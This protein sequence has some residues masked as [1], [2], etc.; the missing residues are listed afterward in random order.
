MNSDISFYSKNLYPD[1]KRLL[2]TLKTKTKKLNSSGIQP[3]HYVIALSIGLFCIY[4]CTE[5][6][7]SFWKFIFGTTAAFA[8][9]FL[10]FTPF[11]V[12][13]INKQRKKLI[14]NIDNII[15]S[16]S[17]KSSIVRAKRIAYAPEYEDENDLYLIELNENSVLHIWDTEYN[18][19]GKF[20]CLDFEIYDLDYFDI[21]GRQIYPLSEKIKPIKIDKKAKWNYMSKYNVIENLGKESINFDILLERYRKSA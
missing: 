18:L 10:I 14:S 13:R 7:S 1:E 5:I 8:F 2:N 15:E 9:G 4:L 17:I 20:P 12:L 6:P 21:T 16:G 19:K 11:E 3:R